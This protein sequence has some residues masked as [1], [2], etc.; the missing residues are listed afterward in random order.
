MGLAPRRPVLLGVSVQIAVRH[1][2]FLEQREIPR[3]Q[4]VAFKGRGLRYHNVKH[5]RGHFVYLHCARAVARLAGSAC[6]DS[7]G[8]CLKRCQ[9][10]RGIKLA[11]GT[12]RTVMSSKEVRVCDVYEEQKLKIDTKE[13]GENCM[14]T[15][16]Q[17]FNLHRVRN[18]VC[19]CMSTS[20]APLPVQLPS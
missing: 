2:L 3:N 17:R 13:D 12:V 15:L 11:V 20:S 1:P 10:L 9:S 8:E 18:V 16:L 14:R 6:W 7:L 5:M 19:V 4:P